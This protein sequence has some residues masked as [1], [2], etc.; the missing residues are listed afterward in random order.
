MFPL[1]YFM[2]TDPITVTEDTSIIKAV[3]LFAE[4][5]VSIIPVIDGSKKLI[6]VLSEHDILSLLV[7]ESVSS[8]TLVK[9]FM[10]TKVKCFK[11]DDSA[12]ELCEY[13]IEHNT[14]KVPVI[15]NGCLAGIVSAHD[16]IK[17][18]VDIRRKLFNH[19]LITP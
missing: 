11:E 19:T 4:H 10:Q 9:S 17:L 1:K 14:R 13:F 5:K 15:D 7:D 12:I 8:E 6:G 2:T 3:E 16:I 18:I